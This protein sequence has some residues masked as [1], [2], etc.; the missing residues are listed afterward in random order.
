MTTAI[1]I[2]VSTKDQADKGFSLDA[3]EKIGRDLCD[4][5]GWTCEMFVE[6][7]G[8]PP[9]IASPRLWSRGHNGRRG[10]ALEIAG[11]VCSGA[12]GVKRRDTYI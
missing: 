11:M 2:R 5:N 12:P 10:V 4:R 9:P 7:G 3:Q 1:Y 8:T 6:S